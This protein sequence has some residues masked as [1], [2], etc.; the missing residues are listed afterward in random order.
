MSPFSLSS[1][2]R[3]IVKASMED[4]PLDMMVGP[5]TTQKIE[6]ITE[7]LAKRMAGVRINATEWAAGKFGHLPLAFENNNLKITTNSELVSNAR[8][9]A[10]ATIH[11]ES[12]K[13]KKTKGTPLSEKNGK[14]KG[15]PRRTYRKP[16]QKSAYQCSLQM[17]RTSTS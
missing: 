8:L 5:P 16:R 3:G 17:S 11:P 7:Q 10:L 14:M 4:R 9:T 13:E 15:G 1:E 12:V 6:V 2:I